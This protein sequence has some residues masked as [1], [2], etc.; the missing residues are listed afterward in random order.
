[1]VETAGW[2]VRRFGRVLDGAAQRAAR[3]LRVA[4]EVERRAAEP[5]A[6]AAG[7]GRASLSADG[8]S[9]R[10]V[11]VPSRAVDVPTALSGVVP[12]DGSRIGLDDQSAR[13]RT[14]PSDYPSSYT[15]V[16]TQTR[17]VS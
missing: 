5:L 3:R 2:V 8:R 10:S 16:Y 14:Y 1:P 11:G 12:P 7:A 6:A 13:S 17:E 15:G 4:D 9:R